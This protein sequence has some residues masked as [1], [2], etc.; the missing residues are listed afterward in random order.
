[1]STINSLLKRLAVV[2]G[3]APR[4]KLDPD[5]LSLQQWADL[6]AY[7]PHRDRAA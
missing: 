2:F 6:P 5:T 3:P 4:S 1:M 7:H